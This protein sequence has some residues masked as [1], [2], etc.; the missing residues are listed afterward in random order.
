LSLGLARARLPGD[1][2]SSGSSRAT[3]RAVDLEGLFTPVVLDPEV[4]ADPHRS[5][6][7]K[8]C[9]GRTSRCGLPAPASRSSDGVPARASPGSD[10]AER[11]GDPVAALLVDRI[12][13]RIAAL[14]RRT[15]D[16]LPDAFTALGFSA[17]AAP[18]ASVSPTPLTAM[19]ATGLSSWRA[20]VESLC[21]GCLDGM[22]E[23]EGTRLDL[24]CCGS[25]LP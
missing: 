15:D 11:L 22:Q 13:E 4:N 2:S 14:T 7:F 1:S 5:R 16:R 25:A 24:S 12:A 3:R 18:P 23:V 9:S 6:A 10:E 17:A 20:R 21:C 8:S 19:S